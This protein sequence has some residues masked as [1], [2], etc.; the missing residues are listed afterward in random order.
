MNKIKKIVTSRAFPIILT[1]FLVIAAIA[2]AA[3]YI[4]KS[5]SYKDPFYIAYNQYPGATPYYRTF[6]PTM[7]HAKPSEYD[8]LEFIGWYYLDENGNEN[9]FIPSEF[10]PPKYAQQNYISVYGRWKSV[11]PNEDTEK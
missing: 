5:L 7:N 3:P 4:Y 8:G 6:S 11:A 10:S 1:I 9:E 2:A